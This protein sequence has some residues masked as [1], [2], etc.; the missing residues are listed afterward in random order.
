MV[1]VVTAHLCGGPNDGFIGR[2]RDDAP[3]LVT[4]AFCDHCKRRHLFPS[5]G[6]GEHAYL[7]DLDPGED[8]H[9]RYRYVDTA[10]TAAELTAVPIAR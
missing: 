9:L 8:L 3:Q 2:V 1:Q 6:H 4:V 10:R 5:P 7:L